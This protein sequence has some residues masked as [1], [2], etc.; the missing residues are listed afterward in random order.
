MLSKD[1]V[2]IDLIKHFESFRKD[3]YLDLR[4]IPTIGYGTTNY[5]GGGRVHMGDKCTEEQA[6]GWIQAYLHKNVYP[7]LS[8]YVL[9][10]PVWVGLGSFLYN[11]GELDYVMVKSIQKNDWQALANEMQRYNKVAGN[12]TKGLV[13]RRKKEVEFFPKS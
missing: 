9:P 3:A 5:P 12:V 8:R 10:D 11:V 7:V 6:V 4:G 1:T 2:L 13:E